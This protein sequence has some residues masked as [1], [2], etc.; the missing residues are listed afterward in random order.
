M[1]DFLEH[2]S[3]I[4]RMFHLLHLHHLLLFQHFDGIESLIM[5]R[6]DQMHPPKA[7]SA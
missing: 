5:L 3:L 4:I 2:S 1:L 6:L 7:T